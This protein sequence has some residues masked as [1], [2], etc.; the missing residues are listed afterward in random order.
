MYVMTM[1]VYI[2]TYVCVCVCVA[3]LYLSL[4]HSLYIYI[5]I[6]PFCET[7]VN[8]VSVHTCIKQK[9]IYMKMQSTLQEGETCDSQKCVQMRACN[10]M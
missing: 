4:S 2:Y 3:A 6:L 8:T 7:Y 1:C 10:I 5:Y 9:N